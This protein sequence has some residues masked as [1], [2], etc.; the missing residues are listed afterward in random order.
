MVVR[1]RTPHPAVLS[2]Q[3]GFLGA[4][5]PQVFSL[6]LGGVLR[7]RGEG[8]DEGQPRPAK[9]FSILLASPKK[10]VWFFG[11]GWR[12]PNNQL[13]NIVVVRIRTPHP[14]SPQNHFMILGRGELLTGAFCAEPQN[15]DNEINKQEI[16][17]CPKNRKVIITRNIQ[18]N[19]QYIY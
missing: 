2:A 6:R 17:V 3:G 9:H 4:V 5:F 16:G 1:I 19:T 12:G 11:G 14:A 13:K 8:Q 10:S 15:Y 18:K 7:R